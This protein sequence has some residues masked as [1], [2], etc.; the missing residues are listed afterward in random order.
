[1][2]ES[3][4][5]IS[6]ILESSK[7][8]FEKEMKKQIKDFKN[9]LKGTEYTINKKGQPCLKR[10]VRITLSNFSMPKEKRVMMMAL[11]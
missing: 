4:S 5:L 8:T 2:S 11:I 3:M 6:H 10:N 9:A 1:M 7:V